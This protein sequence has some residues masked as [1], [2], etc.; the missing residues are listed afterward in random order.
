V[1]T[2]NGS[3]KY[4]CEL[5]QNCRGKSNIQEEEEEEEEFFVSKLVLNIRKKPDKCC[6]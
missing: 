2:D 4:A 6:N 5:I 1:W 3:C